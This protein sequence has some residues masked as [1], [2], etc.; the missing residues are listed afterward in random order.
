[1]SPPSPRNKSPELA[2]GEQPRAATAMD[3]A[4]SSAE[5]QAGNLMASKEGHESLLAGQKATAAA[6]Q[7]TASKVFGDP[8]F[9][10]NAD[11]SSNL[12]GSRNLGS[13]V[14]SSNKIESSAGKDVK[15]TADHAHSVGD[16]VQASKSAIAAKPLATADQ[17]VSSNGAEPKPE[18]GQHQSI[19]HKSEHKPEVGHQQAAHKSEHKPEV[20]HQQAAHKSEHKPEVGHQQAAHKS[21]HKPEVGHQQAAHKSEH[22]PEVGHQQAAHKSEHK[23]EV[24][25]Q[26]AAHKSEHKPEVGHQQAAHKSEHKPEVGHQQTAHKSEHKP[27][28]GHQQAEHKT[29]HKAEVGHQPAEPKKEPKVEA[30]QPL[31][32]H[33]TEH[34]L[35]TVHKQPDLVKSKREVAETG[36]R[37]AEQPKTE[38]RNSVGSSAVVSQD[39]NQ[40]QNTKNI[41]T[42][43]SILDVNSKQ[44]AMAVTQKDES[45]R[46]LTADS[47]DS[48]RSASS[49]SDAEKPT[50]ISYANEAKSS[51]QSQPKPSTDKALDKPT[52]PAFQTTDSSHLENT[53]YSGGQAESIQLQSRNT[54]SREAQSIQTQSKNIESKFA[55]SRLDDKSGILRNTNDREN[56]ENDSH[57]RMTDRA[58]A[59]LDYH[60]NMD[61][62]G[63]IIGNNAAEQSGNKYVVSNSQT[64]LARQTATAEP[65]LTHVVHQ[66]SSSLVHSHKGEVVRGEINAEDLSLR[67][68]SH[69]AA[70][71]NQ[72]HTST[73][74]S[75]TSH[76]TSQGNHDP[77]SHAGQHSNSSAGHGHHN[78]HS[79]HSGKGHGANGVINVSGK[80]HDPGQSNDPSGKG[81]DPNQNND[82]SEKAHDPNQNN[83]PLG[84]GHDPNQSNDPSGN[85]H[86]P[87]GK[88]NDPS[89]HDPNGNTPDPNGQVHSSSGQGNDPSANPTNPISDPNGHHPAG[90]DPTGPNCGGQEPGNPND[91]KGEP[92]SSQNYPGQVLPNNGNQIP[93]GIGFAGGFANVPF[94]TEPSYD[95]RPVRFLSTLLSEMGSGLGPI[96]NLLTPLNHSVI[97]PADF[98]NQ[99]LIGSAFNGSPHT[100][101][102][103]NNEVSSSQPTMSNLDNIQLSIAG[104]SL[105]T[106]DQ[107][108][109]GIIVNEHGPSII[110]EVPNVSQLPVVETSTS[111]SVIH[112]SDTQTAISVAISNAITG[113]VQGTGSLLQT[114]SITPIH[115]VSQSLT[116]QVSQDS[117]T[118]I[119]QPYNN[120]SQVWA[121]DANIPSNY[122]P[123][124]SYS[125][126]DPVPVDNSHNFGQN[127][128]SLPNHDQLV[129]A[130][131]HHHAGMEHHGEKYHFENNEPNN[132]SRADLNDLWSSSE[133]QQ[134]LPDKAIQ[135]RLDQ[136]L[137]GWQDPDSRNGKKS[138]ID[139]LTTASRKPSANSDGL[140]GQLITLVNDL[141]KNKKQKQA[142]SNKTYVVQK[143]DTFESIASQILHD[144]KLGLLIYLINQRSLVNQVGVDWHNIKLVPGSVLYLPSDEEI[145]DFRSTMPRGGGQSSN[146]SAQW[147]FDQQYVKGID[148]RRR[149][150]ERLLGAL[151]SSANAKYNSETGRQN[152]TVRLGDTLR[153]IALKHPALNDVSL[154]KLLAKCNN[155]PT[156]IDS[157]GGP[158]AILTRG[159]LLQIPGGEEVSAYRA[160]QAAIVRAESP[161]KAISA[162]VL[163]V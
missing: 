39:H 73:S 103:I 66:V 25:H 48:N 116:G 64:D 142:Q 94:V 78:G 150:V 15:R 9:V 34:K 90:N 136:I 76:S 47:L 121:W 138:E 54:E 18:N 88:G 101:A 32:E 118:L 106:I 154:W 83:D 53:K 55:E 119:N 75:S 59:N 31:A 26:Q 20:G 74:H 89:G 144:K 133:I 96:G 111:G 98:T 80:G 40:S 6:G 137:S 128:N 139:S 100:E 157:K 149:N 97:S 16:H 85:G 129:S 69:T 12:Q 124:P 56:D 112:N 123:A 159:M 102:I 24:G 35:E 67:D 8:T 147:H 105:A 63:A 113:N 151:G 27:E 5:K 19:A 23:P 11:S 2:N 58:Q 130:A 108:V 107:Q 57:E 28:V 14:R 77:A 156:T 72:T 22:K 21:E 158:L 152:V 38:Q 1:M 122:V 65:N 109:S 161:R 162:E 46:T 49:K 87:A 4:P 153:S 13:S 132:P 140:I 135:Q 120:A 17:R 148:D 145:T 42:E 30:G 99:N 155:L 29:E 52:S 7:E 93:N 81:H 95:E 68:A 104:Q 10:G 91:H 70:Q 126:N 117:N 60:N 160:S 92:G 110:S 50:P 134:N 163:N 61:R 71:S 114:D 79:N 82:P 33:K 44:S 86:D 143:A 131:E 45:Q 43:S 62:Q 141:N 41:G 36:S 146:S 51:T 37:K 3:N 84:K 127:D 125:V 115:S